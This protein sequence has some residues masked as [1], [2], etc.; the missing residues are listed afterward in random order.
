MD[1][2]YKY[3]K[4]KLRY[5]QQISGSNSIPQY[6]AK[7]AADRWRQRRRTRIN[8]PAKHQSTTSVEV[9]ENVWRQGPRI[10]QEQATRNIETQDARQLEIERRIHREIERNRQHELDL[11]MKMTKQRDPPSQKKKQDQ[12]RVGFNDKLTKSYDAYSPDEYDRKIQSSNMEGA[13][14]SLSINKDIEHNCRFSEK[15]RNG[16][17]EAYFKK[18][19]RLPNSEDIP[20]T[21]LNYTYPNGNCSRDTCE[22]GL[23]NCWMYLGKENNRPPLAKQAR[24]PRK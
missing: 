16:Y 20:L 14:V 12:R 7:N 2:K 15:A 1:L 24:I 11:H 9:D 4:Y 10:L 3:K 23:G 21:P 17:I 8:S 6:K 18:H 13:K 5:K 22:D 19:N